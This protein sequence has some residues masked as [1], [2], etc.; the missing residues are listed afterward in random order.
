MSEAEFV[1]PHASPPP[2]V[3]V[4]GPTGVGKTELAE[5][6][7]VALGGEIVSADSMQVYRGMD[8]G[9]SKQPQEH[10]RVPYHCIDLVEPGSAY[11]AA[12]YQRDARAAFED[13]R[14]RGRRPVLVGGTGLY[15]RAALDEMEFPEGEYDSP[16]RAEIEAQAASLGA[17]GLHGLLA[18][19]DPDSA[20]LIHPNNVR[21][22]VRALE[23]L[24]TGGPT[25]AHQAARFSERRAAVPAIL[26]GLTMERSALCARI[27]E[28][29][30]GMLAAGLLDE[31]ARLLASGYR[32][33]LTASQA[34]GYKELVPVL[35]HG[36]DVQE[37][38]AAIKRATRRYAKRQ[39]TWF[40]AD[41]RIS[42]IDVTEL[43]PENAVSAASSLLESRSGR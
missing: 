6:L 17:A 39:L 41:P 14:A 12:V 4:V 1:E 20:A 21:R 13:I 16:V 7:A 34:I 3:A 15:V 23:M 9:T 19:R 36:A 26:I 27:D 2:V 42:W 30:D 37:A 22:V 29:V 10:R 31:V 33:A 24:A 40:R 18:E 28:R 38:V 11:S 25:Y 35:E 5:S 32:G 43:S 8:I